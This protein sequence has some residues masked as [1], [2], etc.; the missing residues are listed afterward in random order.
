[1][2]GHDSNQRVRIRLVMALPGG[3]IDRYDSLF[4]DTVAGTR[5]IVIPWNGFGHVNTA[6]IFDWQGPMPL[7][8]VSSV[9]FVVTDPGAGSLSIDRVSLQPGHGQVGWP[10]HP[11]AQRRSLPPWS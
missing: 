10:F 5:T 2:T 7:G 3:G 6:G 11:A 9:S 4:I 8:A 1:M